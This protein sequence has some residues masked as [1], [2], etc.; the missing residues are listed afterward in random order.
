MVTKAGAVP[1]LLPHTM[2]GYLVPGPPILF[3]ALTVTLGSVWKA[4]S[5]LTFS[6]AT[7]VLGATSSAKSKSRPVLAPV[8]VTAVHDHCL[9]LSLIKTPKALLSLVTTLVMDP[10]VTPTSLPLLMRVGPV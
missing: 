3:P 8:N 2:S 9:V 10:P 1:D 6:G 7:F 5:P 4:A